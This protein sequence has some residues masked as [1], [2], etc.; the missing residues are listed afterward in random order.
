M[1][2]ALAQAPPEGGVPSVAADGYERQPTLDVLHYE[3]EIE[4]PAEGSSI[5]GRTAVLYQARVDELEEVR[6]DF[7][8]AMVV[9]S[10]ALDG[11]M[12]A[13]ERDGDRLAIQDPGTPSG[14]RSEATVWY[15]GE[16]AD[17]L[18]VRQSRHGRRAIFADNWADR[19]HHWFPSVDHPSD[20]ATVELV[21]VAPSDLEVVGNG[22]LAERV[23]LGDGRS[24]TRWV[25]TAEIPVYGMV[26]GAADFAVELAG[27]VDGIEVTHW[28]FAE[29]S[30]AGA[31]AFARSTEILA[32]YDSLFGPYPYEKLAHV[33]SATKF[34]GMENPGAIFYDQERI[35]APVSA[36]EDERDALTSLVAHETVHQWFGDAVT[37]ADWNHLWLSEGF[38]EYFDAV[39]FEFHGGVHGRG[40][41]ELSRQMRERA[42][43]V[44]ELEAGGP[45]AIYAPGAGPGEYETLLDAE[46]YEKGAWVLHMLRRLVGDEA[47]FDGVRDYYAT[48]RGG[49]AWT[50]DFARVM[51]EAA[52]QPLDWFFAQWIARPG[53]PML[54]TSVVDGAAGRSLRIE[55]TQPGEP[56]RLAFIVELRGDGDA[57]RRA[58]EMEG[59]RVEIPLGLEGPVDVVV[60]PDGWLLF[61]SRP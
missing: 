6:L 2:A 17:G 16:P 34:G 58:V 35:G 21:V 9:D 59:R 10:V 42:E 28:T 22:T 12:A 51:G 25:E 36:D 20:K 5:A 52:G 11:R 19:G 3:I 40:P 27:V 29:D 53:M 15:H 39:F 26:I 60:D 14:T 38:A 50:A 48:L 55:Q 7:G 37:E 45:Q 18:I 30:A 54:E 44:R 23:D 24:R 47:F 31:V 41:A 32:F 57:Q 4:V 61:N 43:E 46:N 56:Y 13:F 49:T 8:S 1:P 33:Q